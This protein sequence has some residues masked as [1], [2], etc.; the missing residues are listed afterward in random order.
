MSWNTITSDEVLAEFTPQEQAALK[1]IQQAVDN[2][3]G[4][5][6]RIVNQARSSILA[7]GGR[8]DALNTIPD[9]LRPEV[10][11]MARWRWLV[12]FPTLKTLQTKERKDAAD[13]AKKTLKEVARG[14]LKVEVPGTAIAT[15]APVNAVATVR[16]GRKI[17]TGSFDKMSST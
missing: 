16:P 10:I 14:E 17:N 5:L 7:G 6:A 8:L 2:L 12:S 15:V 4:I 11:D 9:Q 1:N 13:E 3:P